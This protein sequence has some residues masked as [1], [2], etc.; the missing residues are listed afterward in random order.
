MQNFFL[1]HYLQ[2]NLHILFLFVIVS[3]WFG[4]CALKQQ[5][6]MKAPLLI[7][8]RQIRL[9]HDIKMHNDAWPQDQWWKQYSDQQ[10]NDLIAHALL[11]SP[12]MAIAKTK[13]EMAKVQVKAT[14]ASTGLYVGL[15]AAL[16]RQSVSQNGFLGP[17][18]TSNPALGTTGPWYTSGLLGL[19]ADYSIDLWGKDRA[20]V[21]A[22]IGISR[23]SESEASEVRLLLSSQITSIYYEMQTVF[24]F[25]ALLEHAHDIEQEVVKVHYARF[26]HGLESQTSGQTALAH[27]LELE[28]KISDTHIQIRILREALRT[29]IGAGPDNMPL[30]IPVPLPKKNIKLPHTLGYELL[31]RRPD[32]QAMHWYLASSMSQIEAAK[33]AFYPSFDIKAFFGFDSL[34]L[35]DLMKKSSQQMNFIPGLSLPIFDSGRL[36]ANLT[37]ANSQRNLLINEYNQAILN[38]VKEIANSAIKLEG[39][40]QQEIIQQAKLKSVNFTY[41]SAQAH[42]ER[43][44][45]DKSEYIEAKL[46]LLLEQAKLIELQNKQIQA[47]V[48]LITALGGGYKANSNK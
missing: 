36:N 23:A 43:G 24:A 5:T 18:G 41:E 20:R 11:Y 21:N 1:I 42:F 9:N 33:A 26:E 19:G 47:Q 46:P 3:F 32:L 30:I 38:A 6:G 48:A 17:F 34:H 2:K 22:A 16:D 25:Q 31:A 40:N 13:L 27:Q 14:D 8:N 37:L 7:E 35:E 44:L 29:L 10:L 28:Q 15:T 45:V 12:E 4:G 39:F